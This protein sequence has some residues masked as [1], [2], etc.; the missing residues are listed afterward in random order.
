MKN[1]KYD[2]LRLKV[3]DIE[4]QYSLIRDL[5]CFSEI[6]SSILTFS[7]Y[8]I[9]IFISETEFSV[10]TPSDVDLSK[11]S[12]KSEAN[13]TCFHI[14]G[15]MPFGSVQGLISQISSTLY[16]KQ[17]GI[18]VVSTFKSD[19]FLIRSKYKDLGINLLKESGWKVE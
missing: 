7:K 19:W 1:S 12:I 15:D 17:I 11:F 4:Y 9:G 18:C 14:V 13:W 10:V 8:P 5:S 16:E 2:H 3:L 6:S